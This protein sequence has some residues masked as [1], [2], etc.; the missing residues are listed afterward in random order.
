[1]QRNYLNFRAFILPQLKCY[2]VAS[3]TD[4]LKKDFVL[5][6]SASHRGIKNGEEKA[7]KHTLKAG[8]CHNRN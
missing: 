3:P 5:N 6:F 4:T 8:K 2:F 7:A 1:M